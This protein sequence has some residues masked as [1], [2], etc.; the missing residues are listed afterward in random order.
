M[1][2]SLGKRRLYDCIPARYPWAWM[3]S[4]LYLVRKSIRV[5]TKL[6]VD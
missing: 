5:W 3:A 4:S 6:V 1:K 2:G